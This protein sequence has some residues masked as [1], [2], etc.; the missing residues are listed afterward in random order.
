VDNGS[1]PRQSALT[2]HLC[3]LNSDKFVVLTCQHR[4]ENSDKFM[5][6]TCQLRGENIDKFVACDKF[7][8]VAARRLLS[9]S[10]RLHQ[11]KDAIVDG[12]PPWNE[13]RRREWHGRRGAPDHIRAHESRSS[14]WS[15]A[16]VGRERD[17]PRHRRNSLCPCSTRKLLSNDMSADGPRG[18]SCH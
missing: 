15:G 12:S 7:M 3:G 5:V 8:V 2:C 13:G 18:L 11:D 9:R 17:N 6:L 10:C 14:G 1:P 16:V 4:G